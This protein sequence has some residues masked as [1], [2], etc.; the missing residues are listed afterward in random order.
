[1]FGGLPDEQDVARIPKRMRSHGVYV[2]YPWRGGRHAQGNELS[3]REQAVIDR[4]A[5]GQTNPQIAADLFL[6]PRTHMSNPRR[7]L[8]LRTRDELPTRHADDAWRLA[9]SCRGHP[10]E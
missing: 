10:V 8:G 1:M 6:S 5:A 7:K 3:H 4:A 2:P 9:R